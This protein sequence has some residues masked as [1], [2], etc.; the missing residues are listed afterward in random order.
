MFKNDVLIVYNTCGIKSDNLEEYKN[1]I[2]SILDQP[3]NGDKR[4]FDVVLSSCLN[5]EYCRKMLEDHFQDR[6]MYSYIDH[7]YTVNITFN[8]TVQEVVK[9]HGKYRGY[10]FVDSGVN[11]GTQENHYLENLITEFLSNKFGMV[12]IQTDTD[13]GFNEFGYK[14]ESSSP[15]IVNEHYVVP[16]GKACNLHAQIFHNDIFEK[17]DGKIIPDVFAA[18]CTESTFSFLNSAIHKKWIIYKDWMVNHAKAMDGPSLSSR[19]HSLKFGNTWNNLL[20]SR[21]ALDFINDQEAIEA[22]LG[23]E[24][25]GNIMLH[26]KEAFDENGFAISPKLEFFIKKYFFSNNEELNYDNIVFHGKL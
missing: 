1:S 3:I 19:H 14:Y 17:F 25:C 2:E 22:G 12:T 20:F 8:K 26:R 23:Y 4:R 21:N 11:F 10:M 24:E 16:V 9:K 15:Q 6:I 13:T 7:P 5:S 18:Y